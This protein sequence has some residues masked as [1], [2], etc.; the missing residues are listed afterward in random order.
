M[1]ELASKIV[2]LQTELDREIEKR[3]TV[4][5]WS[6]TKGFVAFAYGTAIENRPAGPSQ[7]SGRLR[8][9]SRPSAPNTI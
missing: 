9:Q 1:H 3:R 8:T 2:C 6:V 4:L 5:G 7:Q